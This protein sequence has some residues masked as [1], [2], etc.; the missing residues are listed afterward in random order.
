MN[1]SPCVWI[2]LGACEPAEAVRRLAGGIAL[3]LLGRDDAAS[4]AQWMGV[5]EC[6]ALAMP[7]ADD[8]PPP[9]PPRLW[10]LALWRPAAAC[11][12]HWRAAE[13]ADAPAPEGGAVLD[14]LDVA[15]RID[16]QGVRCAWA[17]GV[18]GTAMAAWQVLQS[19]PA[20]VA[21]AQGALRR[22]GL[23]HQG[24]LVV[25][26]KVLLRQ[27]MLAARAGQAGIVYEVYDRTGFDDPASPSEGYGVVF[28]SMGYDGFSPDEVD[29]FLDLTGQVAERYRGYRFV[30][31]GRITRDFDCPEDFL[32]APASV[33]GATLPPDLRY[34]F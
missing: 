17:A 19:T 9:A 12:P 11:A 5:G 8:T 16:P 31:V 32:V 22:R 26:S 30:H 3:G 25:G 33:V 18:A 28:E 20:A 34:A 27:D 14:A 24:R 23:R 1:R 7:A 29:L 4:R 6:P 13:S 10:T 15:L 2:D 21:S